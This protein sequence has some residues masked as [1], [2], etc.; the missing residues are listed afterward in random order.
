MIEDMRKEYSKPYF[1]TIELSLEQNLLTGSEETVELYET[2]T[3][4]Q[5]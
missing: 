2:T 5:I 3:E 1:E 4:E